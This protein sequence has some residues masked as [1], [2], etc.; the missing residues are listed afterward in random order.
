MENA[1]SVSRGCFAYKAKGK[2]RVARA[3][4]YLP[5]DNASGNTPLQYEV[6]Q[7]VWED[8]DTEIQILRSD[9]NS[10]LFEDLLAFVTRSYRR[11]QQKGSVREIPAAA[12]ITGVN[13]PDH[14]VMFSNLTSML[15]ERVSPLVASL[16]AKD[17]SSVKALLSRLLAQ[18]LSRPELASLEDSDDASSTASQTCSLMTL[19]K[20]Y[21]S[22]SNTKT[23]DS[24]RSPKKSSP[25]K[26]RLSC[27]PSTPPAIVVILE[28][29]ENFPANVLQDFIVTCS[30]YIDRLP[31]VLVM[32]IATSVTTVHRLLP[33]AVSSLLC[34]EKFQVPP[35]TQY[36]TLMIDKILMTNKF[37]FKLGPKVFQLLLDMFLCHHFSV[38]NFVTAFQYCMM[39]HY[40]TTPLSQLCC[41]QQCVPAMV[42]QLSTRDVHRLQQL[43]SVMRHIE[44]LP[45]SELASILQ[46]EGNFKKLV[47]QLLEQNHIVQHRSNAILQLLHS[48]TSHLPGR[49]L[50]KHIRELYAVCLEKDVEETEG[51]IRAFELLGLTAR[52]ELTRLVKDCTRSMKHAQD[53]VLAEICDKM[54]RFAYRLEHLEEEQTEEPEDSHEGKDLKLQRTDLRSLQKKLQELSKKKRVTPYEKVR[55]ELLCEVKEIV[56]SYLPKCESVVM[57]EILYYDN[58][59]TVKHHLYAAPRSAIHQALSNPAHYLQCDCCAVDD[60]SISTTM[61]DVCIAYK[62]HLECGQ[63]INLFDWLQAF[64]SI[65]TAEERENKKS[66]K[67]D[68]VIQARFIQA[69]SELQFLGFI[70]PTKRKTDHVARLTWGGC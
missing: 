50:G 51:F 47:Q 28:D 26:C 27:E 16:R 43:P 14:A 22:L 37:P 49:P 19:V 31:M 11:S 8:M 9:L 25:K 29:T 41:P 32:G 39:E 54:D 63:L 18:L 70:K 60:G 6:F 64:A 40:T 42:K 57:Y 55:Q 2:K 10:K 58:V 52:D 44:Q 15:R 69:V 53:K 24:G 7:H 12:L 46:S 61:P 34:M 68:K 20:H 4:D 21:T 17:C 13:T 62:L 1:E 33:T 36:L 45:R 30:N 66:S 23:A 48:L 67:P 65:V 5:T 59:A 35:S 56:R 38:L 3:E